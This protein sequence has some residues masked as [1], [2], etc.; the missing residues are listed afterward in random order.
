MPRVIF[1]FQPLDGGYLGLIRPHAYAE[2]TYKRI[3]H[4]RRHGLSKI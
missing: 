3:I 4:V 2:C 1:H